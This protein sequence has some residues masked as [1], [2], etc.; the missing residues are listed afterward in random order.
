MQENEEAIQNPG[1]GWKS[2]LLVIVC[3]IIGGIIGIFFNRMLGSAL[4][5]LGTGISII[6]IDLYRRIIA[7]EKRPK[8]STDAS[9]SGGIVEKILS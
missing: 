6:T 1:I 3:T 4:I 8:G 9:Q 2:S 7:F 5:G